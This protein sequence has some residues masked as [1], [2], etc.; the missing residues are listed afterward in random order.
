M[1]NVIAR[2]FLYLLYG[3]VALA[4]AHLLAANDADRVRVRSQLLGRDVRIHRVQIADRTAR[5]DH[6]AKRLLKRAQR[7]IHR[8]NGEQREC[9]YFNHQTHERQVEQDAHEAQ[10]K[11]AVQHVDASIF[12]RVFAL[13]IDRVQ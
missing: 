2:Q 4:V 3:L 12:P 11:I 6:V 13:Q 5:H 8:S 10:N 7:Q 9:V 1:E